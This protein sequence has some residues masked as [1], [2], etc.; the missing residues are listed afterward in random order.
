MTRVPGGRLRA[1]ACTVRTSASGRSTISAGPA[2]MGS[3]S[4]RAFSWLA[5]CRSWPIWWQCSGALVT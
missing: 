1:A 5:A 3:S 2:T 4:S